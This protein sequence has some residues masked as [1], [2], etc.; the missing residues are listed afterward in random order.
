MRRALRPSVVAAGVALIA[1]AT[2]PSNTGPRGTTTRECAPFT[3]RSAV[4]PPG[5]PTS[6]AERRPVRVSGARQQDDAGAP[7]LLD[8]LDLPAPDVAMIAAGSARAL[9]GARWPW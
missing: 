7:V 2:T 1:P 5:G 4:P 8:H 3:G 6:G 9:I